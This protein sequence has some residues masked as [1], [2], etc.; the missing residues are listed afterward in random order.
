MKTFKVAIIGAG[1]SGLTIANILKESFEVEVIEKSRGVG[2]RMS[3]RYAEPFYFDHGVQAF[4]SRTSSFNNF[5]KPY[6][7]TNTVAE[8]SGKVINIEKG[9]QDLNR[10]WNEKHLVASPNMNS[11]CKELSKD[12]VIKKETEVLPLVN[13]V[14]NKWELK[15]TK[16]NIIGEFDF[17]ISTAP[18]NQTI[19]LLSNLRYKNEAFI[20]PN[21]Q[22]C[23][24][25]M[26]GINKPWDKE[27]IA[28]KVRNNPIKWIS[29]NS[30]K[31]Y[32]NNNV[33]SIVAHSRN[34]WAE[35]NMNTDITQVEEILFNELKNS[36][37]LDFGNL[38]YISTHKWRYATVKSSKKAGFFIDETLGIAATSDWCCTSRI[39]EVWHNATNLATTIKKLYK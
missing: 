27:W 11:L 6:V 37:D 4:T 19:N 24:A 38:D 14:R 26:V 7:E 35:K 28:A 32:R 13:K 22:G 30:T 2:G 34:N 3:T 5:L 8:W 20:E 17:I 29:I 31:P 15:D 23:F 9:K 25:L 12:L 18:S 1:I 36:I 33:T 16:N 39:E 21:M 10:E